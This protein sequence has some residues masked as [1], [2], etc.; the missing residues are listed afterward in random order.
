MLN[1]IELKTLSGKINLFRY[2][3]D[4]NKKW[5]IKSAIVLGIYIFIA[6]CMTIGL[7]ID[8]IKY[9][10]LSTVVFNLL[11][12]MVLLII[13]LII[14]IVVELVITYNEADKI[15]S[16]YNI[17]V[18]FNDNDRR[19]VIEYFDFL[20]KLNIE[21]ADDKVITDTIAYRD[22]VA[23]GVAEEYNCIDISGVFGRV[24]TASIRSN[25]I[26]YAS[27]STTSRKTNMI[28]FTNKEEF[29]NI[30]NKLST[31]CNIEVKKVD[32]WYTKENKA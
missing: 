22:I 31:I 26:S 15:L 30:I 5:C 3:I 9:G 29:S 6:F 16:S 24:N 12:N 13:L 25:N 10:A 27:G 2:L 17:S 14:A 21:G 20:G 23:V 19:L 18:E 32:K 11:S 4:T 8:I 28:L 7:V 1:K